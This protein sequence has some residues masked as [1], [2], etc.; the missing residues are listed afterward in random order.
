MW[1]P[2]D[3]LIRRRVMPLEHGSALC[4]LRL[5]ARGIDDATNS[6]TMTRQGITAPLADSWLGRAP[7]YDDMLRVTMTR[8]QAEA[9]QK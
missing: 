6:N 1:R 7:N 9:H 4:P 5:T 8:W 2:T 3:C